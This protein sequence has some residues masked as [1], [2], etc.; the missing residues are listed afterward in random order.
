MADSSLL[1]Y[2]FC[3]CACAMQVRRARS[4]PL[5][6]APDSLYKPIERT[7]RRFNK[8]AV[9]KTLQVSTNHAPVLFDE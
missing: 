1:A 8:L 4:L 7:P 6:V 3:G 5:P 9:P 2:L